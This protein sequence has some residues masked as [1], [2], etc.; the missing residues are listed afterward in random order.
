MKKIQAMSVVFALGL[1]AC[2]S[3][4]SIPNMK[5]PLSY[6]T[7]PI[8]EVQ[9]FRLAESHWSD[10]AKIRA[11]ALRLGIQVQNGDLTRVQAVQALNQYRLRIVGANP[12]DDSVYD[13]YLRAAVD[14]QRNVITREQSRTYLENTLQG[15][16]KRWPSM[17]K[18][19]NNPAFTNFLLE[20]L[21]M[22]TLK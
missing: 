20:H 14:S 8:M 22:E 19:P 5:N 11:E 15:W 6:G 7:Q 18:K 3:N 2:G 13:V 1:S 9:T 10:V 16:L 21:N 12:I 17:D 4:I